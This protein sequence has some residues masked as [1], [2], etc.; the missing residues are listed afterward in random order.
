MGD[1]EEDRGE[2][3]LKKGAKGHRRGDGEDQDAQKSGE[4]ALHHRRPHAHDGEVGQGARSAM[5]RHQL[6]E[7]SQPATTARQLV[8]KQCLPS[9]A[10]APHLPAQLP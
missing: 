9:A 6:P 3:H 1:P 2:D 7:V 10:T 8:L 5:E 4:A